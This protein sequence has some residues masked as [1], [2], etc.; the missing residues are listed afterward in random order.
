MRCPRCAEVELHTES[1]LG[2]AEV[3]LCPECRGVWLDDGDAAAELFAGLVRRA[4]QDGRLLCEA[5][6]V[7][8][9]ARDQAQADRL[10]G[11]GQHLLDVL[12]RPVDRRVRAMGL[13]HRG[14]VSEALGNTRAA[15]AHYAASLAR[16][17]TTLA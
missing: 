5:G 10:L 17:A 12:D 15:A 1:T 9:L 14:L 13:Y 2:G 6:Y 16:C 7:S 4:P 11:R 3:D 8:H